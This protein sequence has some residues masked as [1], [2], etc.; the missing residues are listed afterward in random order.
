MIDLH[1]H[2][3]F[4]DGTASPEEL[5][6]MAAAAGLSAIALTDH[7][8]IAG[9]PRL[10]RAAAAAGV[11]VVPG[12]EVSA[13]HP[14]GPLHI[15]GYFIAATPRLCAGLRRLR[16]GRAAR[17]REI[18][19]RL[20]DLG[21]A[22]AWGDIVRHAG[23]GAVGRLHIARTLVAG[24]RATSV[25]DAFGR[26]LARGRPAYVERLRWPVA[27]VIRWVHEAG[28]VAVLA[29][30]GLLRCGG[31]ELDSLVRN[32]AEAGLDGIEAIHS[33]HAPDQSRRLQ[34][35]AK[36]LGLAW[37]GGSDYHGGPSAGIG[38][39]GGAVPSSALDALE[40]ARLRRAAVARRA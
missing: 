2:S 22:V 16:S 10:R 11:R 31:G 30:P 5:A 19:R 27:D 32:L 14:S 3:Y 34:R 7:D 26:W 21:V 4:S 24:G 36:R 39:C 9:L 37:T 28:G 29:H 6:A 12:V 33:R 18:V 20:Q 8:T 23:V 40:A 17:N 1:L 15:L 25:E 38:R 35:L 13:A